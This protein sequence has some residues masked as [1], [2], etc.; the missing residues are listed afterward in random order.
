M[1]Y[2]FLVVVAVVIF[3]FASSGGSFGEK[4]QSL[5]TNLR[6]GIFGIILGVL[7]SVISNIV[8]IEFLVLTSYFF[9]GISIISFILGLYRLFFG[10]NNGN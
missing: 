7:F 8:D 6:V 4:V 10:S 5:S 2:I 9:F 3:L 1:F